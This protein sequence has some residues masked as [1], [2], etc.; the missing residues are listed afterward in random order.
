MADQ[1]WNLMKKRK[2][3]DLFMDRL[4]AEMAKAPEAI[5]HL[6][7]V[8]GKVGIHRI[9]PFNEKRWSEKCMESWMVLSA[10]CIM[11]EEGITPEE[12]QEEFIKSYKPIDTA[13]IGRHKTGKWKD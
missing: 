1:F 9:S 13:Y 10:I 7:K 11:I 12:W 6:K 3:L 8:T 4:K 5:T 2:D